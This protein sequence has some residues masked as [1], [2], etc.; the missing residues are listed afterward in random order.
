MEIHPTEY[1]KDLIAING[2]LELSYC[3]HCQFAHIQP[4]KAK[5]ES[6]YAD[7]NFYKDH[8]PPGWFE[9]EKKE[10]PY[11]IP[12]FRFIESIFNDDGLIIDIGCGAGWFMKY[13][14]DKG[15][16][17]RGVEPSLVA[18][19]VAGQSLNKF[20]KRDIFNLSL[21]IKG[22]IYL[23]LILEHVNN[24]KSFLESCIKHLQGKM[25]IVVPNEQN[26]LQQMVGGSWFVQSVHRNYFTPATLR[27][28]L[29]SVGLK[30]TWEG[31]T[32][33]VELF[34]LSGQDYRQDDNIGKEA[35]NFR[36]NFE[37]RPG[38]FALYKMLYDALG[39]GRELV[40]VAEKA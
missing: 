13:L 15:R 6:Y 14:F 31:A 21:T 35:H 30:V 29:K 4:G 10:Y 23:G 24:P 12:Y 34:V 11:W 2:D 18:R 36:L 3:H 8:S 16:N 26:L 17:V 25:V 9:K 19:L 22:H 38:A 20:M 40:F 1:K 27:N 5:Q 7:D 39:I 33:P 28:L 32:F 37:R